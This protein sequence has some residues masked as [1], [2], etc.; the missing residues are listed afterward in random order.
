ML[1]KRIIPC[2]DVKNGQT[3]KGINFL[4]IKEVGDAVELGA[5]YARDGADEL[6]FLDITAT[7]EKRKT[8]SELVSRIARNINI[9]F[10]VGGGISSVDDVSVLLNCGADKISV[11]TAA[12]KN[13]QLI[14]DLALNFGSQCVVLAVDTKFV[15]GEWLVYLNG[16]RVPT[17]IRTKDWVK[18]AVDRGAGEILLTSMNNDGTKDGFAIDITK[19][20]SESV[21]VPVIASGGAGTMEHFTEVFKEG[22]A[23]AALAASIFH[24]DEIK[25]AELKAYLK[26]NGIEIRI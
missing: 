4:N 7:N 24:Y 2:L 21:N 9:P 12:V 19:A 23:D 10:T 25:I 6:V 3:V 22:K 26:S 14:N 5:Q 1:T 20:V 15:D 8:L 16:G 18:E 17:E 11:N 13:P